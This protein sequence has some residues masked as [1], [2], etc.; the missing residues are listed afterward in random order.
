MTSCLVAASAMISRMAERGMA[1]ARRE[2]GRAA[3]SGAFVLD[4]SMT[5]Q[6]FIPRIA[7][8]SDA[9]A[10]ERDGEAKQLPAREIGQQKGM[11]APFIKTRDIAA[12]KRAA[13]IL[14]QLEGRDRSCRIAPKR[15]AKRR[16]AHRIAAE[17]VDGVDAHG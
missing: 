7:R 2:A 8:L 1:A 15:L 11:A 13:L 12:K 4:S 17:L 3:S 16:V 14:R 10:V 6:L 5:N 9:F